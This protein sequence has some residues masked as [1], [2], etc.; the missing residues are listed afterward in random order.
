MIRSPMPIGG[1]RGCYCACYR[2]YGIGR[3]NRKA[4]DPVFPLDDIRYSMLGNV[5]TKCRAPT[6]RARFCSHCVRP[7]LN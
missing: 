6:H 5:R 7:E 1:Y 4:I 3:H 2:A